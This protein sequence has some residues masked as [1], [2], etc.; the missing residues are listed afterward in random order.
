LTAIPELEHQ[1][2]NA[3]PTS[4]ADHP[5]TPSNLPQAARSR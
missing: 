4:R 1:L 3:L 5:A 2:G